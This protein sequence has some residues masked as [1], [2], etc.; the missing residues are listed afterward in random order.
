KPFL[1]SRFG[2][3]ALVAGTVTPM[4]IMP[5]LMGAFG[6]LKQFMPLVAPFSADKW[7]P[8]I[9]RTIFRIPAWRFTHALFGD[10]FS[11]M[12][13]DRL[14]TAWVPFLFVIVFM[15]SVFAPR[16]I[17]AR[18][19][20]SFAAAWVLLGLVAAYLFS[21]AGPCYAAYVGAP[22]AN[23]YAPLMQRLHAI[24]AAGYHLGALEWQSQLWDAY[25][26]HRYGFA[27]G[28]SAFPSMHNAISF[29]YVLAAWKARPWLRIL[30]WTF[31][32]IILIG[33][34]H[35]GWHYIADG[36]VAWPAMAVIWW[37]SGLYLRKCGYD[38]AVEEED[39]EFS[40]P[41]PAIPAADEKPELLAA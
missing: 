12:V 20:L 4:L 37:G 9:G 1:K 25:S 41:A 7:L 33:S 14:Y 5:L 15:V 19:F 2:S 17:R 26:H 39:Y 21:S 3:P 16:T 32:S 8:Q 29:L 34:V 40:R 10:P 30:A 22:T 24:D 27:L 36:L 35:L 11:T 31:A 38:A 6:A 18:F 28:I 23:D 13:I